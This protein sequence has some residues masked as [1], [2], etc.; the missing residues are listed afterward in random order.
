MMVTEKLSPNLVVIHGNE[1]VDTAHPDASGGRMVALYGPDGVLLVDSENKPVG[2]K[3]LDVI[4]SLSKAPI[5]IMVNS[6]AHS[7]HTGGNAFFAKQGTVIFAQE[8]LR[9]EM[10]PDPHARPR[11]A[12]APAPEP[13]D[14]M[15]LPV[16]TYKYDPATEGKP[17]VTVHMNGETVDFIPMM[18]SHMGGDTVIRFQKAN[19]IYIEDFYRNFGYPFADQA[20]GGSIKGMLKAVDLLEKLANDQTI[21]VPGHGT[22][23]HRKDLLGY[24]AMLVDLIDKVGKMRASGKSLK[25]VIAANITAPYDKSTLG[26]TQQSKD[27]FVQELYAESNK[28]LPPIMDGRR[29]MPKEE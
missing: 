6:H 11:P 7:D 13:F 26:D 12:G 3:S 19:V 15:S 24:R 20:N 9:D 28:E 4:R 23:V 1:G 29:Q 16:V 27:R 8:N 18:P 14:P 2:Q 21:L 5:K 17:A 25:D 22:L 10:M